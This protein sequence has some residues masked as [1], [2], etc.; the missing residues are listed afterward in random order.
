[1]LSLTTGPSQ[2]EQSSVSVYK[3]ERNSEQLSVLFTWAG[4]SLE[5]TGGVLLHYVVSIYITH[6]STGRRTVSVYKC[7]SFVL[8]NVIFAVRQD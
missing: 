2:I 6:P 8:L 5:Q 1:M 4:L 7:N 3:M